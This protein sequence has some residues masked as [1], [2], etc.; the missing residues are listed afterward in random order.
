MALSS[1]M[2]VPRTGLVGEGKPTASSS[3]SARAAGL[4][5]TTT[6]SS[7]SMSSASSIPSKTDVS[8]NACVRYRDR[9][10]VTQAS[11]A[12]SPAS[13]ANVACSG[14]PRYGC[15]STAGRAAT[16]TDASAWFTQ[17]ANAR[18]EST[19]TPSRSNA[20]LRRAL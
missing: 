16:P 18:R 12:A 10:A 9:Y 13:R 4:D 17:L 15:S 6:S 3:G 20:T 1:D 7:S 11:A 14:G 19:S 5:V 2:P 8:A